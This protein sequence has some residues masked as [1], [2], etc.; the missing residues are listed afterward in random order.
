MNGDEIN[1][2]DN[3]I[4]EIREGANIDQLS[5]NIPGLSAEDINKYILSVTEQ[6]IASGMESLRDAQ[7]AASSSGDPDAIS[8]Y[9][10]LF[11]SVTGSINTLNTLNLQTKKHKAA[12]NL[13]KMDIKSKERIAEGKRLA[14]EAGQNSGNAG[15][16]TN[17]LVTSREDFLKLI[18]SDD[19]DM[20]ID[21]ED[22][23]ATQDLP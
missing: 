23:E 11:K 7:I 1:D 5:S 21:I 8:A 10:A 4:E 13:K 17:I 9:G 12:K 3:L 16:N 20:T 18:K 14:I 6:L 15:G 22:K 2:I 19:E